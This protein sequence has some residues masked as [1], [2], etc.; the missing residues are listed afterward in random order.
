[1]LSKQ[2]KMEHS[3]MQELLDSHFYLFAYSN[4]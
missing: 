1:M 4:I 2:D 3:S